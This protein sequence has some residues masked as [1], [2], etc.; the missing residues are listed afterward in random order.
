MSQAAPR[1][2]PSFTA[3]D[4]R[5]TRWDR[6]FRI[7]ASE[8]MLVGGYVAGQFYNEVSAHAQLQHLAPL[9]FPLVHYKLEQRRKRELFY[10]SIDPF[11]P[12]LLAHDPRNLQILRRDVARVRFHPRGNTYP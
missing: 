1:P 2:A 11:A 5:W 4:P 6:V 8:E 12:E 3:V 9:L 10:D 7:Y